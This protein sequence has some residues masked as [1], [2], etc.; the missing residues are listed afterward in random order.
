MTTS[1]MT[2]IFATFML[3]YPRA[4]MFQGGINNLKPTI[5]LWT[6]CFE[7]VP[8]K[9]MQ[10]AAMNM[11]KHSSYPP[12]VAEMETELKGLYSPTSEIR[13]L[14][15]QLIKVTHKILGYMDNFHFTWV[16]ENGKTQGENFRIKAKEEFEKLPKIIKDYIGDF[17]AMLNFCRN[18]DKMNSQA[19]SYEQK[20]FE[21]FA[22]NYFDNTDINKLIEI[23]AKEKKRIADVQK[24]KISQHK[25]SL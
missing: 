8:Y 12:T 20:R 24:N 22:S 17:G 10:V 21:D 18:Y 23:K 9:A 16:Q 7:K 5:Q 6:K 14:W 11:I 4:E 19:L 15:N 3:A 1:E 25:D 2:E 13:P